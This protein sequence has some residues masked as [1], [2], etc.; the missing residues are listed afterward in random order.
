MRKEVKQIYASYGIDV[1]KVL[2]ELAKTKISLHCWQLDDVVGFE[3]DGA[4]TDR[5]SVV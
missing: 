1:N 5:K 2:K 4:L 3:N